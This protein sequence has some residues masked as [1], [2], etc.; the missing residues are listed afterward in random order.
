MT[1]TKDFDML[2]LDALLPMHLHLA[3][4]GGIASA[5]RTLRR[6]IGAETCPKTCFQIERPHS[7]DQGWPQLVEHAVAGARVFLRLRDAPG[8]SLR[9]HGTAFRGGVLMNLGFGISLVEAVRHFSLTDA[10]FVASDLAMEFLFIHEANRAVMGE[11]GR[12][13]H[14]LDEAREAAE[15]LALTDPLTG[16]LNRRG[17]Q[18]ALELAARQAAMS[19]FSLAQID[20]DHFK[21]VNDSHGHAAGDEVLQHVAQI[22]RTE[23]RA[24]DRIARVGGDEFLLLLAGPGGP[25]DLASLA[26]RIIHR[27]EMPIELSGATCLISASMGFSQSGDYA[28]VDTV[29]MLMDADAALYAVKQSGRGAGRLAAECFRTEGNRKT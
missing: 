23:T 22:L 24:A 18:A 14:R 6:L 27:I 7:Q 29:Q 9:G 25:D 21:L 16:L 2:D 17:F 26:R 11:L 20:L 12:A 5:G 10:D 8:I 3:A 15:T 13:N 28:T 19:P 4:D 1:A